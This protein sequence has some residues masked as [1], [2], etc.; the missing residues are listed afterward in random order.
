MPA[1]MAE[2][3]EPAA[4]LKLALTGDIDSLNP[5]LAYLVTSTN[6]MALQYEPLV[7]YSADN[8]EM[9]PAMAESWETSESGK[10]W[11]VHFAEDRLRSDG[12][13]LTANDAAWTLIWELGFGHGSGAHSI[14]LG[15]P[16]ML[17]ADTAPR[18]VL[19]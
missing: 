15:V 16:A 3:V 9:V 19:D 2:T 11:T 12:E 5:F 4:T 18:L 17:Y 8:Y 10:V 6:I 1:A 7:T 14:P 13:P